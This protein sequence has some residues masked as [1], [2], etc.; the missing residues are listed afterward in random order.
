MSEHQ[1]HKVNALAV[2]AWLFVLT[3]AEVGLV[4]LGLSKAMLVVLL[5][6]SAVLKALIVAYFFM[7]LKFE[8]K[9]IWV[10]LL[11]VLALGAVFL[12]ALFP[13]MVYSQLR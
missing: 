8:G 2:F 7:H 11:A 5:I 13:D 6:G 9:L 10:M 1:E 4:Y 3:V 12:I